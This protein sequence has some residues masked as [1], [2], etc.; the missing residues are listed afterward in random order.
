MIRLSNVQN[1]Q[2]FTGFHPSLDIFCWHGSYRALGYLDHLSAYVCHLHSPFG[3]ICFRNLALKTGSPSSEHC[4]PRSDRRLAREYCQFGTL[5]NLL[6][7]TWSA[8]A[9][10]GA[11][12]RMIAMACSLEP[13]PDTRG[14][15]MGR[16]IPASRY[17]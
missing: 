4:L 2:G 14:E 11:Q 5:V 3:K 6:L 10:C 15:T 7:S 9:Y 8:G 12:P 1:H 16:L 17:C 13:A